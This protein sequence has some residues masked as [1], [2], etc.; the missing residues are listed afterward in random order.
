M[1]F[2]RISATGAYLPA[3]VLT[4][5]D[6]EKVVETSDE[7]IRTRTGIEARR[8]ADGHEKTEDMAFFAAQDLLN[9][10]QI[11]ADSL[12]MILVATS[13]ASAFFP[14]TATYVAHKLGV[15]NSI[16]ALDLCTACA[17][18]LF[19]LDIAEKYILSKQYKRILLI[20]AEKM[21]SVLDWNDRATCILFGDG[22]AAAL[23]E[24]SD[25]PGILA[26]K[27]HMEFD[28]ADIL[29]LQ[30]RSFSDERSYLKMQ[31]AEVF[32]KA[33]ASM[34][35]V[36]DTL[37]QQAKLGIEDIDWFVPHQANVRIVQ[38]LCKRL[39]F[40]EERVI[41]TLDKHGNTSAASV[42]LALHEALQDGRIK[43]GDTVLLDAFGGG[44]A[45]GGAVVTF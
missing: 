10:H 12:D 42:P 18:F 17:G 28:Q 31:G 30:N 33:V 32:K 23:L 41:V 25:T 24:A 19:I 45:W 2:A 39:N 11:S 44:S 7:W 9:R 29:S 38:A 5:L 21:S 20:G 6:L 13:T 37:L 8:I 35:S 40:P 1:T 3:R 26:S 36:V 27:I 15:P 14:N 16:P 43:T 22:A 34:S 4:N